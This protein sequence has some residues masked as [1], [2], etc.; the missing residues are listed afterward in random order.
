MRL[1]EKLHKRLT[2]IN[3]S[4]ILCGIL[5]VF[6]VLV[7][8]RQT[9]FFQFSSF[10]ENAKTNSEVFNLT[11]EIPGSFPQWKIKI[12]PA[13]M[14]TINSITKRLID[15][16]KAKGWGYPILTNKDKVWFP[17]KFYADGIEYK[18][19]IRIRGDGGIH[20]MHEKKSWRI[21][22]KKDQLFNGNRYLDLII[23]SDK[24]YELEVITNNL[25]RDAGLIAP[26]SGFAFASLNEVSMGLYL[27]SEGFTKEMLER[28]KRPEGEIF[29]EDNTWTE[30][31]FNGAGIRNNYIN[32]VSTVSANFKASFAK[33]ND[34]GT[35]V[36]WQRWL[37][38]TQ[39]IRESDD[40]T[41]AKH[42]EGYLNLDNY[43][44]WNSITWLFGS[45]HAHW[46]D[47]L[48]WYYDT[49]NGLFEP[50]IYDV[51]RYPID[52][53][54]S[55]GTFDH[56]VTDPL[57]KRVM[58]IDRYRNKRNE[59]LWDMLNSPDYNIVA[60]VETSYA[61]IEPF[62]GQASMDM[63]S[64]AEF[65]SKSIEILRMNKVKLL[66]YLH[67]GRLFVQP[68]IKSTK[69]TIQLKLQITPDSLSPIQIDTITLGGVHA[70]L[71]AETFSCRLIDGKKTSLLNGVVATY[72]KINST[73]DLSFKNLIAQTPVNDDLLPIAKT[74]LFLL[75]DFPIRDIRPDL[76]TIQIS[77]KNKL[78]EIPL[79]K[80]L[81]KIAGIA[82]SNHQSHRDIFSADIID[83]L[84]TTSLPFK[85]EGNFLVLNNGIY[86]LNRDV[87]FPRGIDLKI[88]S[89][90]TLKM[91]P[92]VSIVLHGA[93]VIDGTKTKPVSIHALNKKKPWGGFLILNT[94]KPSQVSNLHISGGNGTVISGV[95]VTGQLAFHSVGRVSI[96]N[97][98]F[99]GAY[100]D[101]SLNIKNSIIN[102]SSCIFVGNISD[103][104]DGDWV[105]G[106]ITGCDF[107]NNT[108]DGLDVSGSEILVR[109]TLF[110]NTKD[111]G[112]SVGEKTRLTVINCV[113]RNCLIGLAVKDA[114]EVNI[115][116]SVFYENNSALALYRKK[117]LFRIG[118][119]AKITNCLFWKN[120]TLCELDSFSKLFTSN[121]VTDKEFVEDQQLHQENIFIRDVD[122]LYDLKER[123]NFTFKGDGN[124]APAEDWP[125]DLLTQKYFSHLPDLKDKPIGLIEANKLP[126]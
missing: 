118:G 15:K 89:G 101:D 14:R 65:H 52:I 61:T 71:N 55:R 76:L 57:L 92:G 1:P 108:G 53:Q 48:R 73:A 33:T 10:Y 121:S 95:T 12:K 83:W 7:A 6:L 54:H 124:S 60:N 103:G 40:D 30:S 74:D 105:S 35:S 37:E 17:A 28:Q 22:F 79:P 31:R 45:L 62:L 64:F 114:S 70:P 58:R 67:W 116:S 66:E 123:A 49:T 97:S 98:K 56:A 8:K 36:N 104:F 93:L 46:G 75:I 91:A 110:M 106:E 5:G 77:A 47:N 24:A 43:F 39:L 111:K 41:F 27:W 78:T 23:P 90:V 80:H 21:R 3:T 69:E 122:N 94:P 4:L 19:K 68:S 99:H 126:K 9:I 38:F 96:D 44:K 26:Q 120:S 32:K 100:C 88:K 117:Q 25:A 13:H 125:K 18:V 82:D 112:I 84:K 29:K 42:V 102:I 50:L 85:Q 87:I 72:N 81:I 2:L 119:T 11:K 63:D 109:N 20:W 34:G 16:N 59:Y 107:S 113:M 86:T 115:L 51:Y